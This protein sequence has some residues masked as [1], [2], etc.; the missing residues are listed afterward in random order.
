M[1]KLRGGTVSDADKD[2]IFG[3]LFLKKLPITI[4]TALAIHK[5]ATLIQLAEMANNIPKVQGPQAPVY[6]IQKES[7]P[8]ITAIQTELQKISKILQSHPRST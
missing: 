2:E 6:Q 3:Q 4:H 5:D 7:N 1:L 8:E